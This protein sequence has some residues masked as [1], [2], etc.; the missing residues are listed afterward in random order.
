E[1]GSASG[2]HPPRVAAPAPRPGDRR[3]AL[4]G[5]LLVGHPEPPS[6][7]PVPRTVLVPRQ[8]RR[9][10]AR[11]WAELRNRISGQALRRRE[12]HHTFRRRRRLRGSQTRDQRGGRLP[13]EPRTVRE[14]G[15]RRPQ[16]GPDGGP[17]RNR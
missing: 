11:R 12:T 2:Y 15:G 13:E 16:R 3:G 10:A 17:A 8:A 5:Y 1:P 4:G 14:G 7:A 6:A 9:T